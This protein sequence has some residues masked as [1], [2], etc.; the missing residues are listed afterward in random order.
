ME[1]SHTADTCVTSIATLPTK[2]RDFLSSYT[3]PTWYRLL[4]IYRIQGMFLY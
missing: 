2:L 4:N 1:H 3:E